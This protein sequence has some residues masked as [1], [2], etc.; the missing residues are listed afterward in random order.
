MRSHGVVRAPRAGGNVPIAP[1]P[2]IPRPA[3]WKQKRQ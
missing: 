1:N 3:I 2:A